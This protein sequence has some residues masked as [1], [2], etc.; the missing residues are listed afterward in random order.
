[1]VLGIMA[2]ALSTDMKIALFQLS[3]QSLATTII[4]KPQNAKS[5]VQGRK[6]I[7]KYLAVGL[8]WQG[9]CNT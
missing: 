1:M 8:L 4:P 3:F 6:T 5:L 9:T 2:T 7:L